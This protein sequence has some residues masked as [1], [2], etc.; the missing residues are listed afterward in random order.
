MKRILILLAWLVL[1]GAS[2]AWAEAAAQKRVDFSGTWVLQESKIEQSAPAR[3]GAGGMGR[4]GRGTRGG[5]GYPGG[6]RGAGRTGGERRGDN[7]G[8]IA[9][10][11]D[12]V[13]V[14]RQTESELHV[15]HT[16][17]A[18]DGPARD[19]VQV[20]N[21]DGSESAN[22][23]IPGGGE[24]RSRTSWDKLKLVTLGTMQPSGPDNAARLD[25]V[26]KEEFSLSK[27]GKTLTLK[28]SR[29]RGVQVTTTEVFTRQASA[30][31]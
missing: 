30:G 2:I 25:I 20:F 12:S 18:G 11:M 23:G 1:V 4:G 15:T 26:I 16:M 8:G 6:G 28:T 17:S 21:L 31:K 29:S 3:G 7:R 10:L 27:D 9:P 5:G 19:F 24:Y 14:I 22:P 13:L